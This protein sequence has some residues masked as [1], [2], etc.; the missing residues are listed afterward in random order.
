MIRIIMLASLLFIGC[1]KY[2]E[3]LRLEGNTMGTT[4]RVLIRM[5][6]LDIQVEEASLHQK[7]DDKLILINF[8]SL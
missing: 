7:I 1:T 6:G 3:P 8:Q 2:Q 5:D 4:Y